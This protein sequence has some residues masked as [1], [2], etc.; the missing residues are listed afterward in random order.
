MDDNLFFQRFSAVL[1]TYKERHDLFSVHDALI[2][3]YA[4]TALSLEPD[5]SASRVVQDRHA[6]GVDAVLVDGERSRVVF[7]AANTADSYA[8]TEHRLAEN[9]IKRTLSGVQLLVRGNY[10][11]QITPQLEN[12]VNE[13]HD[14]DKRGGYGTCVHFVSMR[15]EPLS[16]KFIDDF[17]RE[18]SQVSVE[19]VSFSQLRCLYETLYLPRTL[20]APSQISFEVVDNVLKKSTPIG[21]RVFTCH[22]KE[23]AKILNDCGEAL[24]D[25][26]V[27]LSLGSKADSINAQM[28]E[29]AVTS[30][31]S[32]RFWYYNN[33]VTIVCSRVQEPASGRVINLVN[34]QV[35]NGAQTTYA[36]HRAYVDGRLAEDVEVLVKVIETTDAEFAERVT[37]YTNSQNPIRLRDLCSNDAVQVKVQRV[38]LDSYQHFY[39]RKAGELDT[40]YPT[41]EMKRQLLG[42]GFRKRIVSNEEAAQAVLSLYHDKPAQAKSEKGRIF[43]KTANGFYGLVFQAGDDLLPEKLLFSWLLLRLIDEKKRAYRLDYRNADGLTDDERQ[44]VYANDFLL[45]SDLFVLNLMKDFLGSYG[46]SLDGP[47]DLRR[48]IVELQ[49]SSP[50]VEQAYEEISSLF[51]EFFVDRKKEPDYYH[52]KFFK[53]ERSLAYLRSFCKKKYDFIS[54][55]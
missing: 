15:A 4:E 33:G 29:T 44:A 52:N 27:R 26:N 41:P 42:Q 23:L 47:E 36:L 38:L 16:R 20:G 9:D 12:L 40:R 3:W 8:N 37:L 24:F 18:L 21:S 53:N 10:R 31:E 43:L 25:R 17:Q 30:G 35:I 19:I 6:E 28:E 46:C 14:L 7:V 11:G 45:H 1:Q 22:G 32:E 5:D 39:E 13:Y 2:V 34:P 48:L 55:L 54:E 49:S 51:T 50:S